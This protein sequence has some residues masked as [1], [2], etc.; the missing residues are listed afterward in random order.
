MSKGLIAFVAVAVICIGSLIIVF[1]KASADKARKTS[2]SILRDFQT[3]DR[4]LK[5]S[6]IAFDSINN[7][8]SDSLSRKLIK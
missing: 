3:V 4:N 7:S 5:K 8:L 1:I 6:S 2:D